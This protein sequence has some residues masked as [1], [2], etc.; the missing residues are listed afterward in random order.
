MRDLALLL[1]MFGLAALALWRPWLGAVGLAVMGAMHPQSYGSENLAQLPLFKMLFIVTIVGAALQFWHD[2]RWP[3]IYWDWRFA[4]V[5]L[6]LLDFFLTAAYGLLPLTSRGRL[7]EFVLLLLSLIPLLVLVDTREKLSTLIVAVALGIAMVALKG[8]YWAVMTGFQD[9]VYG[10]PGSQIGGNNEFAV[11]L[12]MAIPLLVF[13]LHQVTDRPVRLAIRGLIVLCYI[14]ALTSWSRGGLVT[15]AAMTTLLILHSRQKYLAIPFLALGIVLA[16]ANLPQQWQERMGTLAS[17][18]HDQSFQGRVWAWDRGLDYLRADPLTGVGMD[19][20]KQVNINE[21]RETPG[22]LAWHSAYLQILV[23][24]GIPGFV[25]WAVL[26]FGSLVSLTL[27][28]W[29]G[30]V[31]RSSWAADAGALLRA[32][33]V[34][35]AVGGFALSTA[36]WELLYMLIAL[37]IVAS[38]VALTEAGR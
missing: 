9:R 13:W 24:H 19:G 25:L 29:R 17:Y 3:A 16:F 28:Q 18:Q 38:R 1:I 35:Y 8:G 21:E 2:R 33:L 36:Y 31:R 10:P 6:L 20:W 32:T 4:V 11:A 34:A 12:A 27:L 37:A 23:E 15:L 30:K 14:A 26:L 22:A 7:W 5:A